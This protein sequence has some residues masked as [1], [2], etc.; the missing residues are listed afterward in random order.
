MKSLSPLIHNR[1]L[2]LPGKSKGLSLVELMISL[3]LGLILMAAL[4]EAYLASKHVQATDDALLELQDSARIAL[5]ILTDDIRASGFS[6]CSFDVDD[7]INGITPSV[8]DHT[9]ELTLIDNSQTYSGNAVRGYNANEANWTP[10]PAATISNL[11]NNK[12][13]GSDFFSVYY[14]DDSGASLTT[15]ST[16]GST[17]LTVSGNCVETNDYVML[18]NCSMSEISQI[19]SAGSC[20]ATSYS[21]S[22]QTDSGNGLKQPHSSS[23]KLFKITERLYYIAT[24][25]RNDDSGNPIYALFM[26]EN[27][28]AGIELVSGIEHMQ[29]QYGQRTGSNNSD[30]RYVT[31]NVINS[32]EWDDVVS[33]RVSLLVQSSNNIL[34]DDDSTDYTVGDE[35]I[36]LATT[37]KHNSGKT[38]RKV[39]TRT[40]QLRNRV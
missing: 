34:D 5:D 11:T 15:D 17:S 38:L 9:S 4:T 3:S 21:I 37:I 12:R 20:S 8:W 26:S 40:I 39:F 30:I 28:E 19:V 35:S 32:N 23:S 31:A 16:K 2:S 27:G 14:A 24:T 6:G 29:I 7:S 18:S 25:G 10:T 33:V 1:N 36:G 22:L 13:S